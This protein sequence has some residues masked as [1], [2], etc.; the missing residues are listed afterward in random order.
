MPSISVDAPRD[1]TGMN[2]VETIRIEGKRTI[3]IVKLEGKGLSPV[4]VCGSRG[5]RRTSH[6][7]RSVTTYLRHEVIREVVRLHVGRY[8]NTDDLG[9]V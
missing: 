7:E 2:E 5:K 3:D 8:V 6:G 4:Q 9:G 1:K